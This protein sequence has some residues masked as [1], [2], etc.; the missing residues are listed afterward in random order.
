MKVRDLIHCYFGKVTFYVELPEQSDDGYL[1]RTL[2]EG[3]LVD[4]PEALL[5]CEVRSFGATAAGMLDVC[6]RNGKRI[7]K[8]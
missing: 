5:N 6:L 1:F 8:F 7:H 2:Y 4:V 3:E